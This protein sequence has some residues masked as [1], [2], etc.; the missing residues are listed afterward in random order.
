MSGLRTT[1]H[2][3]R[4]HTNIRGNDLADAA[5]KL[6]VMH[7][8][9]LPPSQT[10]RVDIGELAPRPHQWV[11]YTVKPP[12][13]TPAMSTGTNCAILRRP[14]WTILDADRLQMH[15]FTHPSP[16]LR[17]KVRDALLRSLHHSSLYMRLIITTKG[18]RTKT[19]G[20]ALHKNEAHL[21]RLRRDLPPKV[22]IRATL[23]WQTSQEIRPCPNG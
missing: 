21:Q 19:V 8:D 9:T 10:K 18:A 1:L 2:K 20:R 5:A 17:L 13:P 23:Q 15:A 22:H 7:F 16:Q 4:G 3:L 11:M 14:W 6:A 12:P